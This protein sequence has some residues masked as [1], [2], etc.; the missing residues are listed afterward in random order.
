[1]SVK[2]N[3]IFGQMTRIVRL[4]TNPDRAGQHIRLLL[5]AM[6]IRG[7]TYQQRRRL[8]HRLQM[9]FINRVITNGTDSTCDVVKTRNF[10]CVLRVPAQ[11]DLALFTRALRDARSMLSVQ[12]C[13]RVGPLR[14]SMH[15]DT[16]LVRLLFTP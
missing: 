11:F 4:C 13:S 14:V 3:A 7:I 16:H 6:R 5:E 10:R 2:I 15:T 12:E 8:W 1:M 9:W